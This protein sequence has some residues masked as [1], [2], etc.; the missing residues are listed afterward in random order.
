[1]A[2]VHLDAAAES[3]PLCIHYEVFGAPQAAHTLLCVHELGG[4]LESLREFAEHLSSR[5]RVIIFDQRGAG[6]SE[7]PALAFSVA[8]LAQ[9]IERLVAKLEI[10]GGFH[11]I[12]QAMGAI[13]SL[14]YAINHGVRLRSL[15]L[16]DGTREIAASAAKYLYR[17][18]NQVR[19]LGMRA[20]T[21]TTVGYAFQGI[22][23]ADTNPKWQAYRRRFRA[24]PPMSYALHLEALASVCLDDESLRSISCPTFV[25]S[26]ADDAIWSPEEGRKLAQR[27]PGSVFEVVENA[28]HLPLTQAAETVARRVVG[29]VL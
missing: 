14:F 29:F 16:C 12:G 6:L 5:F 19:R 26:G 28:A 25:L 23:D 18:A 3:P 10:P 1:M 7:H 4:S 24:Y 20:V 17:S 2:Y 27:I 22:A 8:D 11:L 13:S 21:D 9:D 15:V